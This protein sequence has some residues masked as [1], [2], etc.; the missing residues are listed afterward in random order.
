MPSVI[1]ITVTIDHKEPMS[2]AERL[3]IAILFAAFEIAIL[4]KTTATILIINDM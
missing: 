2:S 3:N 1:N 4:W